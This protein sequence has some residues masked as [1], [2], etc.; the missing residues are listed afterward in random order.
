MAGKN[1][2]VSAYHEAGHAVIDR[3]LG[4]KVKRVTIIPDPKLGAA[5]QVNNRY[6]CLSRV[7]F[8]NSYGSI[9]TRCHNWIIG[10]FAGEEAQRRHNPRSVRSHHGAHDRKQI[11]E[12]LGRLH[13]E[14]S[15]VIKHAYSYLQAEARKLVAYPITWR[16]IEDL[17][18]ALLERKTLSG[19][20]VDDILRASMA[21]QMEEYHQNLPRDPVMTGK[22]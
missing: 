8:D 3:K 16:K 13:G 1:L 2:V 20:E 10:A 17:A 18:K 11:S 15:E 22:S 19:E 12:I 6:L 7:Q 4:F 14:N 5:G 9:R 21:R